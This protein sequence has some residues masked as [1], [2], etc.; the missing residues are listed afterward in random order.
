[1]KP[2]LVIIS[3]IISLFVCDVSKA[4]STTIGSE[5]AI[6]LPS[7]AKFRLFQ[8]D[9]PA[10][11]ETVTINPPLFKW[12]YMEDDPWHAGYPKQ[13][14]RN[15]I[16]QITT[17]GFNSPLYS[18]TTSN[19][20]YN[21]FDSITNADGSNYRGLVQWRIISLNSNLVV[22]A[23]NATHNFI[24]SPSA[25]QWPRQK[26]GDAVYLSSIGQ[27]PHMFF[28]AGNRTAMAAFLKTNQLPSFS[29][30]Q[31]TNE[32]YSTIQQSWWNNPATFTN[33]N[34]ANYAQLVA[35]VCLVYQMDPNS[36]LTNANPG[37]MTALLATNFIMHGQDRIDQNQNSEAGKT[38]PLCYDWT[39]ADMNAS[40]RAWCVT[41]LEYYAQFF[42]QEDWWYVGTAV[43]PDRNYNKANVLNYAS[44]AKINSDHEQVDSGIGLYMTWAG[45]A[46]S[47]LLRDCQQYFLN[48]NIGGYEGFYG[49]QERGYSEQTFRLLHQFSAVMLLSCFDQSFTNMGNWT[50][51]YPKFFCYM[52][53]LNYAELQ[54]QFGDFGLKPINGLASTYMYHNKFWDVSYLIGDGHILQQYQRNKPI[55]SGSS[56]V[57]NLYGEAYVNFYFT[58]APVQSDWPDTYYFDALDGWCISYAYPPNN[59]NCFTNGVGFITTARPSGNNLGHDQ[60]HDGTIDMFAYGA[61]VSFGGGG[62][63]YQKHGMLDNGLFVDGIGNST[64]N[65]QFPTADI[66]A[67]FPYFTNSSDFTFVTSD[68]SRTFNN[69]NLTS[70]AGGGVLNLEHNYN[71][72]T[73]QRPDVVKVTRNILFP[74]KKYLVVYDTFQTLTNRTFQW[75][76]S[77]AEPTAVV[78]VNNC[79]FDYTV[80]N[81]YNGSNVTVHIQHIVDPTTMT[82]TNIFGSN[83]LFINPWTGED[84]SSSFS[85]TD[86]ARA[87]NTIWVYNKIP[88]KNW[89]F[90]SVIY[91]VQWGQPD[92]TI[93][94]LDDNTVVVND[95]Q[96]NVDTNTFNPSFSGPFTF[97]VSLN[98]IP[99]PPTSLQVIRANVGKVILTP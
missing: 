49:D 99:S 37:F 38:I 44:A 67:N 80:T 90:M 32:V 61:H 42:I 47:A 20:F 88:T 95:N 23:T 53:P 97:K 73:N 60:F 3:V 33:L 66:Y 65:G 70:W 74:H 24:I 8:G 22:I 15:F 92:P 45:M 30:S 7:S 83:S 86:G 27:H 51:K 52:E 62:N 34:P 4:T 56:D 63:N 55:R 58:N 87:T 28:N 10:D 41:V 36:T 14:L 40:Q 35:D 12:I 82:L 31:L 5:T 6:T 46:E 75:K 16:I 89:H 18:I 77:I 68:L 25:K 96:G 84:L 64:P 93:T 48:Y 21:F 98:S 72:S 1:M 78:D 43:S 71:F 11:G 85:A 13:D 81:F 91:P 50:G 17:N 29:W 94:R 9:F 26:Y 69:T 2:I 79:K 76:W 39:F 57:F 19:N 59:W 54:D